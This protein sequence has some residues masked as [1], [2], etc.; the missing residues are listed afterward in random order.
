MKTILTALIA[1]ILL[2][3]SRPSQA[4]NSVYNPHENCPE[5]DISQDSMPDNIFNG[6]KAGTLGWCFAH[7]AADILSD[8]YK[9][10]FS[11]HDIATYFFNSEMYK[12]FIKPGVDRIFKHPAGGHSLWALK[13]L[14]NKPVCFEK[15]TDFYQGHWQKMAGKIQEFSSTELQTQVNRLDPADFLDQKKLEFVNFPPEERLG[16]LFEQTC[17]SKGQKI[18]Y[19]QTR[20]KSWGFNSLEIEDFV[21]SRFENYTMINESLVKSNQPVSIGFDVSLLFEG[22]DDIL[23][24]AT[25]IGQKRINGI[26]LYKIRNN[27][28]KTCKM[29]TEKLAAGVICDENSDIFFVDRERALPRILFGTW[30]E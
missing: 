26:C 14:E 27:S 24:A 25:L 29:K 5:R 17:R 20:I 10:K 6:E 1:S 11:V 2:L 19:S 18:D 15:D 28:G 12:Q 13:A 21:P 30:F 16:K 22:R 3:S 4:E 9:K 8:H 23:H 7:S